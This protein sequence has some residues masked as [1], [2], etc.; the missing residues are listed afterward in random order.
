MANLS[1]HMQI[2]F[3]RSKARIHGNMPEDLPDNLLCHPTSQIAD[4]MAHESVS[5]NSFAR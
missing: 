3:L 4:A 2:T 1:A 5:D